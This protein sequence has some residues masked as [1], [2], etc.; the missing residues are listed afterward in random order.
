MDGRRRGWYSYYYHYYH[1]Y[2]CYYLPAMV[3]A[4]LVSYYL[5]S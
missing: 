5:E 2:Y 3:I 4:I 1:Y